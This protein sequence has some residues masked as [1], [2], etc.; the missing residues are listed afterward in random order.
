MSQGAEVT[1][2]DGATEANG[3]RAG[4]ETAIATA[5][6]PGSEC[7][8][9][10]EP[11]RARAKKCVKCESYQDWRRF[12]SLSNTVL[13]LL[14]ALVSVSTAAIPEITKLFTTSYSSV[15]AQKRGIKG[16]Q[17]EFIVNNSGTKEAFA[18]GAVLRGTSNK[19]TREM[20]LEELGPTF[21]IMPKQF[22]PLPVHVPP[23]YV[24]EF[25]SWPATK[26]D[27]LTVELR[28]QEYG[29]EVKTHS[30]PMD[31]SEY[32]QFRAATKDAFEQIRGGQAPRPF[33]APD[34]AR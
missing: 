11:I 28:I 20:R 27:S 15:S 5:P 8:V 3:I 22:R 21:P 29:G 24:P 26:P 30:F 17:I 32:L 23:Y 18:I 14:V 34:G 25:M 6:I 19:D 9:C 10:L 16:N 4:E 13:A 2:S 31:A 1:A 12:L 33:P 7:R